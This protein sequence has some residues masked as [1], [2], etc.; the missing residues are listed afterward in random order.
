M[1]EVLLN[2][3]LVLIL[4]SGALPVLRGRAQKIY[5]LVLPLA[6]L[7]LLASLP[8]GERGAVGVFGL[9]LVTLRL[10]QLSFVFGLVFHLAAV[11][12]VVY[13]W[14]LRDTVQH[15]AGLTYAGAA[16]GALLA[17][18]LLT[19]FLY[20]ELTSVASAVLIWARRNESS[21]RA[22]LRYLLIQVVSG[23]LL[24]GGAVL[25]LSSTG[26]IRFQAMTLDNLAAWLVLF[27]FGIKC[28]FPLLHNW[29]Q[30]SYPEAT[31]TGSVWLSV[32]TTK[33]AVYAL[34][35]GFAGA[36]LLV[37]IGVAMTLFPIFYAVIEN[38]LRRVLAYSLNNQLGFMVTGIGIGT[39]LALNGAAAHAFAHI[40][41]KAL[42]FMAMGAVLHQVGA[43]KASELGGLYKSMPWT[44][45][46]CIIGSMSISAFPL[47]SGFVT[48]SMI[49]AAA[50]EEGQWLVY[51]LLLVA[52]AGVVDHSGIKIPFFS[53]FAH[54]S[55]KRP[56]EA[57]LNMRLAMGLA[58]ALCIGIG[59]YPQ[60]LYELLP[61]AV[62]YSAFTATHVLTQLQLLL[63]AAAAFAFLYR[64]AW[65][66]PEVPSVNLDVDWTYRR[67]L[68]TAVGEGVQGL[69]WLREEF[70]GPVR[71][72]ARTAA[73]VVTAPL[74]ARGRLAV[75]WSTGGM[76]W[77]VALLLGLFLLLSVL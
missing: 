40:I 56:R 37:W 42:L 35:R 2:P 1:A 16:L 39:E 18:D 10:D 72:R 50:V 31:V 32:Y 26:S 21:F 51:L 47:L 69:A 14:H 29:L 67:A 54:D 17:G 7:A 34:A 59:L 68:P 43:I 73:T 65:Y 64:R 11:L 4:G 77:W 62:D 74:R 22:G 9:E 20:W 49:L 24:L 58:A 57:P 53:F 70:A 52:S 66:P 38:D 12:A 3:A 46:F 33:L 71:H 30:D 55:G 48:K 60:P 45:T 19:L 6:S 15:V 27:A 5:L 36:E 23:V 75:P 28:A 13:S 25:Q 63:F 8:F 41:Y 76:V 44:A 61:H